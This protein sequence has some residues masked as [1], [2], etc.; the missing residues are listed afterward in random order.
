MIV[1]RER[2]CNNFKFCCGGK[3]CEGMIFEY[4]EKGCYNKKYCGSKGK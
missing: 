4:K 1:I 3:F 2:L